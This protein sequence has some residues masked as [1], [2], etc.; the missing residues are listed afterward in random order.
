MGADLDLRTMNPPIA[1]KVTDDLRY[2]GKR[3]CNTDREHALA[4]GAVSNSK[5]STCIKTQ[6]NPRTYE[7]LQPHTPLFFRGTGYMAV[8]E[9][10]HI[11]CVVNLPISL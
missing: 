5:S 4:L 3:M 11:N 6:T 9:R 1:N 10:M 8:A 7:C 2:T